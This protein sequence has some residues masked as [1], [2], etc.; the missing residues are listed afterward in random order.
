[1]PRR[2]PAPQRRL[3][4]SEGSA[5]PALFGLIIYLI[6]VYVRP[7][8]WVPAVLNWP[9]ELI[10]GAAVLVMI[11]LQRTPK[12]PVQVPLLAVWVM[13]IFLANAV[14]GDFQ[15][16]ITNAVVFVKRALVFFMFWAVID[17][18]RNLRR[19]IMLMVL[20]S[21][22]LGYQ[23]IWMKE[24]GIGW[25]GQDMYWGERIRWI[26]LWDGANVLSLLFVTAL[27]YVLELILGPKG[28]RSRVY[29]SLCG[30]LILWG[31]VLAGSRGA[32]LAMAVTFLV[33]FKDRIGNRGLIV[34]CLAIWAAT[35]I[36][37]SRVQGGDERDES[38]WR[39]R[40]SMWAEG[41]EMLRYQ[42]VLG[43]GKGKFIEHSGRQIAHNAFV[44]N[45]A[46]TGILGLFA[47]LALIYF[48][49]RCLHI[50]GK[51]ASGL[52]PPLESLRRAV[53]A[54]LVGYLVASMFI[55]T[56]FEPL[57][58]LMGL[59]AAVLRI[60]RQETGMI[61]ELGFT[62]RDAFIILTLEFGGVIFMYAGTAFLSSV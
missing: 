41:F 5:S 57:Y 11:L 52:S 29:G 40:V 17:S 24:H 36:A 56:D 7:A 4:N 62:M 3:V 9:L 33:Y 55:S 61:L 22:V 38:S 42:P 28:M 25:A 39:G 13:L 45:M 44:Q 21:A 49:F 23:G 54:G 19:V 15:D 30:V 46:E 12:I 8:D 58:M 48:S 27:P 43:V 47:W 14:N 53:F 31:I 59:C 10:V 32:W 1:M 60:A 51:L 37:P 26:G 35:V 18:T 16:A 6:L 50:A 20:L 34:G 2:N